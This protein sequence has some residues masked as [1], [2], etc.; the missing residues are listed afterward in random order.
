M[1]ICEIKVSAQKTRKP[2]IIIGGNRNYKNVFKTTDKIT[3]TFDQPPKPG[4]KVS[5]QEIKTI[6]PPGSNVPREDFIKIDEITE[7]SYIFDNLEEGNH[8][9]RTETDENGFKSYSNPTH[10]TVYDSTKNIFTMDSVDCD[11]N[12]SFTLRTES[13]NVYNQTLVI[14]RSGQ[15]DEVIK[16]GTVNTFS[17]S[18]NL[19]YVYTKSYYNDGNVIESE[20]TDAFPSYH[21]TLTWELGSTTDVNGYRRGVEV[22]SSYKEQVFE[23]SEDNERWRRVNLVNGK[24]ELPVGKPTYIM[25]VTPRNSYTNVLK[26]TRLEVPSGITTEWEEGGTQDKFVDEGTDNP[27]SQAVTY[28]TDENPT[29]TL[30]VKVDEGEWVDITQNNRGVSLQHGEYMR[31]R[32]KVA[33]DYDDIVLYS[34]ELKSVTRYVSEITWSD[35]SSNNI[36]DDVDSISIIRHKLSYGKTYKLMA[37]SYVTEAGEERAG[38]EE[39]SS[40]S[41]INITGRKFWKFQLVCNE[42]ASLNS[43]ILSFRNADYIPKGVLKW[44]GT[45]DKIV[46]EGYRSFVVSYDEIDEGF[47]DIEVSVY[48]R[49]DRFLRKRYGYSYVP[50]ANNSV[51]PQDKKFKQSISSNSYRNQFDKYNKKGIIP[52]GTYI[53]ERRD[54]VNYFGAN[55][56]HEMLRK[57]EEQGIGQDS[58]ISR[59]T[60]QEQQP[61]YE[62]GN[63]NVVDENIYSSEGKETFYAEGSYGL[64]DYRNSSSQESLVDEVGA[65]YIQ[66][67]PLFLSKLTDEEKNINI[68]LNDFT[69]DE[70]TKLREQATHLKQAKVEQWERETD[71]SPSRL[72]VNFNGRQL[73]N[74]VDLKY[75][76]LNGL[77]RG[78]LDARYDSSED[79][80]DRECFP[81]YVIKGVANNANIKVDIN[82][83]TLD[84]NSQNNFPSLRRTTKFYKEANAI[85][86]KDINYYG[87]VVE[88]GASEESDKVKIYSNLNYHEAT[89]DSYYPSRKYAGREIYVNDAY[90]ASVDFNN[91]KTFTI[92]P[93]SGITKI[94]LL[95]RGADGVSTK[96]GQPLYYYNYDNT[97]YLVNPNRVGDGNIFALSKLL[98]RDCADV[99]EEM[100]E[101]ITRTSLVFCFKRAST[102]DMP[103]DKKM[104]NIQFQV[105]KPNS[106]EWQTVYSTG[107]KQTHY[108]GTRYMRGESF[109]FDDVTEK[110]ADSNFN[111][112]RY[113]VSEWVNQIAYDIPSQMV[114]YYNYRFLEDDPDG[115]YAFRLNITGDITITTNIA[116]YYKA[117]FRRNYFTYDSRIESLPTDINGNHYG[118]ISIDSDD[119]LYVLRSKCHWVDINS[120]EPKIYPNESKYRDVADKDIYSYYIAC[121]CSPYTYYAIKSNHELSS[122]NQDDLVTTIKADTP[123]WSVGVEKTIFIPVKR[124]FDNQRS[125]STG[126]HKDRYDS[127]R[128][129]YVDSG[130][131][132]ISTIGCCTA[133]S[134][135]FSINGYKYRSQP[136]YL[137]LDDT[138]LDISKTDGLKYKREQGLNR[139]GDKDTTNYRD[140]ITTSNVVININSELMKRGRYPFFLQ[141]YNK[142]EVGFWANHQNY[143]NKSTIYP[144]S[145][146]SNIDSIDSSNVQQ[147]VNSKEKVHFAFDRL[148]YVR[149]KDD[150]SVY[151]YIAS[152]INIGGK[153]LPVNSMIL[154]G[155]KVT[156]QSGHSWLSYNA[157][158]TIFINNVQQSFQKSSDS[159]FKYAICEYLEDQGMSNAHQSYNYK[160]KVY[161]TN[162]NVKFEKKSEGSLIPEAYIPDWVQYVLQKQDGSTYRDVKPIDSIPKTG[163]QIP[164]AGMYRI[165]TKVPDDKKSICDGA[166]LS[167][168]L[169]ID[170]SYDNLQDG[171][172]INGDKKSI[173]TH[174]YLNTNYDNQRFVPI[175]DITHNIPQ[176]FNDH[177]YKFRVDYVST[178]PNAQDHIIG[179]GNQEVPEDSNIDQSL[180]RRYLDFDN[181]IAFTPVNGAVDGP[182]VDYDNINN[183]LS[184]FSEFIKLD[185]R[186]DSSLTIAKITMVDV[187]N[188]NV[189][190]CC[191]N[192]VY[193]YLERTCWWFS[194][195]MEDGKREYV[196]Q[197]D[198]DIQRRV[199]KGIPKR[200]DGVVEQYPKISNSTDIIVV[201]SRDEY[202]RW[203][204]YNF[205][206]SSYHFTKNPQFKRVEETGYINESDF[207]LST[208][209]LD[210][211]RSNSIRIEDLPDNNNIEFIPYKGLHIDISRLPMK[212]G[213]YRVFRDI[214]LPELG[215]IV[216]NYPLEGVYVSCIADVKTDFEWAKYDID[217]TYGSS[218]VFGIKR[219]GCIGY[220]GNYK[221][222]KTKTSKFQT[223][224]QQNLTYQ[225]EFWESYPNSIKIEQGGFVKNFIRTSTDSD[226]YES[227]TYEMYMSDRRCCN[228]MLKCRLVFD[229]KYEIAYS[230]LEDIFVRPFIV[231]NNNRYI[232][233]NTNHP[234]GDPRNEM[235]Y[236]DNYRAG[237][238]AYRVC[239]LNP[240]IGFGFQFRHGYF[241]IPKWGNGSS[242]DFYK[243]NRGNYYDYRTTYCCNIVTRADCC[244]CYPNYRDTYIGVTCDIMKDGRMYGHA[245]V[246]FFH[247]WYP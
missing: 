193:I 153:T 88:T 246:L 51:A 192:N 116:Q 132:A 103:G 26:Y 50:T 159:E 203:K 198:K 124:L 57:A 168:D 90:N 14:K 185:T 23:V 47:F 83:S 80:I 217:I 42:D 27:L 92:N 24:I 143:N 214:F 54:G 114:K 58:T 216:D 78:E 166:L 212:L 157:E 59:V 12:I 7:S 96:V 148:Y 240:P 227:N 99:M 207:I 104:V 208:T 106:T 70:K 45:E 25:G 10:I 155:L 171:L 232:S 21:C 170:R 220:E 62:I 79:G 37:K 89:Y 224:E 161:T 6:T 163:I 65:I 187:N 74:A 178:L 186:I 123:S 3:L 138:Y 20:H 75:I 17:D 69:E 11:G 133:F 13:P 95:Y 242:E 169:E 105:M 188:G 162:Y 200:L 115:M 156:T 154:V 152:P 189:E 101:S 201:T 134:G 131:E 158:D 231:I 125:A 202:P 218:Y 9:F 139:F 219:S 136:C 175:I 67:E 150:G 85:Q 241:H 221:V 146:F 77:N 2:Y 18:N 8:I 144:Y 239:M 184:E 108:V 52:L 238:N 39:L 223:K 126:Y 233:S 46:S 210:G 164:D 98:S 237:N 28:P 160:Q 93:S 111:F 102:P 84:R 180:R 128:R 191:T 236:F 215:V 195:H 19:L 97:F 43:N 81:V 117:P 100:D 109:G 142:L 56:R 197:K 229:N 35:G 127:Y 16:A 228:K 149:A 60:G 73:V 222:I 119:R 82:R 55:T 211:S 147:Y 137:I 226:G 122:S 32:I 33:Y 194:H 183:R 112:N 167:N 177:K 107:E 41:D 129:N 71:T 66:R 209:F 38:W 151:G 234:S 174:C 230:E 172:K 204:Q 53:N 110:L 64:L 213:T 49:P 181:N 68:Y 61:R 94:Q 206:A 1:A 63:V 243:R 36:A 72:V 4:T 176:E 15:P 121:E 34:N 29:R 235:Y 244:T 245:N 247:L 113:Y 199:R 40:D 145:I 225:E 205:S 140:V 173:F 130:T 182:L 190:L 91:E 165:S 31:Y 118:N 135:E 196:F 87:S 5:L 30:Q 86:Y 76:S 44:E 22:A 179:N 120:A 48:G 141:D